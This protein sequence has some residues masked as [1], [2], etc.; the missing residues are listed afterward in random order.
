MQPE[1]ET[2]RLHTT[3]RRA[4][5]WSVANNMVGRVGTV[6]GGEAGGGDLQHPADAGDLVVV[7]A[8]Q[9]QG[10][11]HGL[12]EQEPQGLVVHHLHEAAAR[13]AGHLGDQTLR[14]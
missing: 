7:D 3:A 6:F 12:A 13:G 10:G 14:R 4:L 11:L 8:A 5:W 2:E 1:A 9:A